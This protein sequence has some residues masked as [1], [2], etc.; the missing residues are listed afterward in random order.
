L[1]RRNYVI[2]KGQWQLRVTA[3]FLAWNAAWRDL[4]RLGRPIRALAGFPDVSH[5]SESLRVQSFYPRIGFLKGG[6]TGYL[7]RDRAPALAVQGF[8]QAAEKIRLH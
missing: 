3:L 7:N 1:I 6:G 4:E 2:S 8:V 5:D